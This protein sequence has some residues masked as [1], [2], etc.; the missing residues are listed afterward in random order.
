MLNHGDNG[1]MTLWIR[2]IGGVDKRMNVYC[3]YALI[4]KVKKMWMNL[5]KSAQISNKNY[6][7]RNW[8]RE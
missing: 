6:A 7:A 5:S 2:K 8:K 3:N 4:S 1:A